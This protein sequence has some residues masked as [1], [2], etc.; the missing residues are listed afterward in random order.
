[1]FSSL[2][3]IPL[4][5]LLWVWTLEIPLTT[6]LHLIIPFIPQLLSTLQ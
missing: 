3:T 2:Q 1:L 4:C 5:F 6:Q